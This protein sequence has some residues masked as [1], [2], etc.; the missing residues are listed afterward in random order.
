MRFMIIGAGMQGRACAFDLLRQGGVEELILADASAATLAS[1]KA[2]LK[3]KKARFKKV[4]ASK[5]AAVI[6]LAAGCSTVVSCVPYFFNLPLAKAAVAAK[7]NFVDLGGSTAIVL[8]E[9]ELDRAAKKAGVGV[10]PDVGLGPGMTNIIAAHAIASLDRADEVLIRDGGLP[11]D[12]RPP[13]NYLL[14]FSEHGLINEYVGEGTALKDGR[15]IT[16]QGCSEIEPVALPGLGLCEA[17]HAAG[18]LST[19]ARTFAG[20]VK[21]LDNKFVRYPGHMGVVNTMNAMG[22]FDLE[23]IKVGKAMVSPRALAAELFR[24]HFDRPGEKDIVVI[25]VTATGVKDR[26]PARVVYDMTDLYDDTHKMTA[27]MRTTGF[28]AAIVARMLADG[29]IKPGAHTVE[30]GVPA[31]EF[32]AEIKARGFSLRR[33]FDWL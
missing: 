33:R 3:S 24:R 11:Q 14:T 17:G 26:K 10:V 18:G 7:V 16:V 20:K 5:P 19:M 13:M 21:T 4:D 22:F 9:L 2:F 29:R 12:P 27:M 6:K 1:A 31:E 23:P 8:K 32:F 28:P 25:R 30:A 15:L